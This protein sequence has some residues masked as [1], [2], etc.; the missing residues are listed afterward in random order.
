MASSPQRSPSFATRVALIAAPDTGLVAEKVKSWLET[1][2]DNGKGISLL[3]LQDLFPKLGS[4]DMLDNERASVSHATLADGRYS[5]VMFEALLKSTTGNRC[6]PPIFIRTSATGEQAMFCAEHEAELLQQL[7][8][9]QGWAIFNV[10]V[11]D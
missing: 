2:P 9:D 10:E 3:A 4:Q 6:G 7:Y 11:F 5:Q 8:D 1:F